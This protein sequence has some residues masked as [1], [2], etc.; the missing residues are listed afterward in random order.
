MK[1]HFRRLKVLVLGT[2]EG[3]AVQLVGNIGIGHLKICCGLQREMIWRCRIWTWME[4]ALLLKVEVSVVIGSLWRLSPLIRFLPNIRQWKLVTHF[5][6][7]FSTFSGQVQRN[8]CHC[9][10]WTS[11]DLL[12]QAVS[13][14]VDLPLHK[15]DLTIQHWD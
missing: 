7:R 5:Y 2:L 15:W 9:E 12:V 14:W 3:W 4:L 13:P 8:Y 11:N 1:L 10:T 6:K